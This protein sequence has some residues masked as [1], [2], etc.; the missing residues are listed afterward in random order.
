MH[1]FSLVRSLLEA[2]ESEARARR[3]TRIVT[4]HVRIGELSGVEEDLF[5]TAFQISRADTLCR[6]ADL[7]IRREPAA[8]ICTRCER[9][10]ESGSALECPDCNVPARLAR[11]NEIL[12][13]RIELEVP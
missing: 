8:W 12:L 2:A 4:L 3:A 5:S 13:E 6:E 11:G 10:I 9:D 1:E 7:R